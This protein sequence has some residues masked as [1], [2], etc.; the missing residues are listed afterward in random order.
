MPRDATQRDAGSVHEQSAVEV[1]M[2]PV[3]PSMGRV[4]DA[5]PRRDPE[6]LRDS[7]PLSRAP[8]PSASIVEPPQD[9]AELVAATVH[10]REGQH[11][12]VSVGVRR[13]VSREASA[14][15]RRGL[16]SSAPTASRTGP[17]ATRDHSSEPPGARARA[18]ELDVA[19]ADVPHA[20]TLRSSRIHQALSHAHLRPDRQLAR[21]LRPGLL[22]QFELPS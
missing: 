2:R 12:L 17:P 21:G 9:V 7:S 20:L 15:E 14:E 19:G 4:E 11:P 1:R 3:Q 13:P 6:L 8:E 16:P 22:P 5:H 18:E 10:R